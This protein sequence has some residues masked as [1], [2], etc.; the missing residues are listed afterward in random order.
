MN[1]KI[2]S[3][4]VRS[5]WRQ[6]RSSKHD[7]LANFQLAWL[8]AGV[9]TCMALFQSLWKC[10]CVGW[11]ILRQAKAF[12]KKAEGLLGLQVDLIADTFG[13]LAKDQTLLENCI[14]LKFTGQRSL[15]EWCKFSMALHFWT[16]IINSHQLVHNKKALSEWYKVFFLLF[17]RFPVVYLVCLTEHHFKS[18]C[19]SLLKNL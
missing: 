15:L 14:K 4:E 5:Y 11:P 12:K 7:L 16:D 10:L 9:A 18:F 3:A 6:T 17:N 8:L 13:V 1:Y 2:S 19:S